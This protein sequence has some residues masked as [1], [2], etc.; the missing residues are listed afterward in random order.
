VAIGA[1]GG[2]QAFAVGVG[3]LGAIGEQQGTKQPP[4]KHNTKPFIAIK[5]FHTKI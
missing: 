1:V 5:H 4:R 2:V 3:L